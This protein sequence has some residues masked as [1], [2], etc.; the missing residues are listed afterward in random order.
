MNRII[1]IDLMRGLSILSI[2]LFH[3]EVYYCDGELIPYD[4]YVPNVLM[5]FFFVSGYVFNNPEKPFSARHKLFSIFRGI[6][7]P[8]FF[9]TI[10]LVVPKGLVTHQSISGLFINILLGNGSWFVTALT[11]AEII[12]TGILYMKRRLKTH[13]LSV[14]ISSVFHLIPIAVFALGIVLQNNNLVE[15]HNYWNFHNAFIGLLFLYAGYIYRLIEAHC[16][17]IHHPLLLL[18][19][20]P[21]LIL[22][23][24]YEYDNGIRLLV[25]PVFLNNWSVFIAD[26]SLSILLL[27]TICRNLPALASLQWIG[28]HSLVIYFFCGATPT[29]MALLLNRIG[30]AYNGQYWQVIVAFLLVCIV[31]SFIAWLCY[32]FLPFLTNSA[33]ASSESA[34]PHSRQ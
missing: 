3:T 14:H 5:A 32:R 11:V 10:L 17:H 22:L 31:S 23:K 4:F 7:I 12:M 13:R 2:L 16:P 26:M 34:S 19:L 30:F 24:K 18:I 28:R 20:I 9:F 6:I 21:L 29:A 27:L 15:N 33:P 1:W 8:Y 25:N